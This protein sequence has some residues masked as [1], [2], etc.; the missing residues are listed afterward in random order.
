M[1][2]ESNELNACQKSHVNTNCEY[3]QKKIMSKIDKKKQ[4]TSLT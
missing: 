3:V 1:T 2:H 4:G